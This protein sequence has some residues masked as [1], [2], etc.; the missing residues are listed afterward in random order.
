VIQAV[1]EKGVTQVQAARLFGVS[2]QAIYTWLTRYR[3]KGDKGLASRRRGRPSQPRLKA[4]Q[5][6]VVQR[7]IRDRCPDQLKLPFVLWTREA[8]QQ[9]I[10]DRM[11]VQVSV[12]TVGRYLK[13]WGFTPQ[14]PLKRAY[15]RDPDAVARWLETEYP[16]IREQ[17]RKEDATL[18]WADEMGMRMDDQGGR[19]YSMKGHTPVIPGSLPRLAQQAGGQRARCSMMSAIT[20]RGQLCFHVFRG[21]L[22]SNVFIDF[23]RRLKR[24]SERKLFV[25]VDRHPVHRSEKT[26]KW[27]DKHAAKV[28]LIFLPAYSPDLNPDEMLNQDVKS[29]A[30]RTKRPPT[31]QQMMDNVRAYLRG[32]Q[33]KRAGV[34]RTFHAPSVRYAAL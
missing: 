30:V 5:A 34:K 20:N 1:T 23:L 13:R 32:R 18:W 24:Q 27:I 9:L 28:R 21:Q 3:A 26:Q 12:W 4:A 8:V 19:S 17:A 15:E 25:I 7:F 33:R 11:G 6:R 10:A 2:R 29:N 14:K 22:N 16:Q 31:L